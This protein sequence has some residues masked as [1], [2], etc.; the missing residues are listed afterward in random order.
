MA[1]K[2][3]PVKTKYPNIYEIITA[4]NKSEY[5]ATW[6]QKGRQYPQKKPYETFLDV[7][8]QNRQT[9]H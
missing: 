3:Q 1:R 6:T 7:L 5:L 8:R 2:H 9:P 4:E